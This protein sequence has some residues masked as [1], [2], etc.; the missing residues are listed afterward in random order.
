MFIYKLYL[1]W[2]STCLLAL[3]RLFLW[4]LL[5]C[6]YIYT[7]CHVHKKTGIYTY[8]HI[9]ISI[10]HIMY[11]Y[12]D[13]Y[14]DYIIIATIYKQRHGRNLLKFWPVPKRRSPCTSRVRNTPAHFSGGFLAQ[15][16]A[17]KLQKNHLRACLPWIRVKF[18][19]KKE[20]N[21]RVS[22]P[23]WFSNLRRI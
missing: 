17:G 16:I 12:I 8:I 15:A 9:Y 4:I 18:D 11:I 22:Y 21:I 1:L 10:Y 23:G 3:L 13:R 2:W 5:I 19:L 6:E 14:T 20:K 7:Y